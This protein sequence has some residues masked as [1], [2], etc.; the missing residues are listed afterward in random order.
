VV[1][2]QDNSSGVKQITELALSAGNSVSVNAQMGC[3]LQTEDQM[4]AIQAQSVGL[5]QSSDG[6]P[7]K[8][9]TALGHRALA[10][11]DFAVVATFVTF[12]ILA[13]ICL[14][15]FCPWSEEISAALA[16]L[17]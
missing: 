5:P 16:T 12:G 4:Q 3:F 11:R 15:L 9:L 8:V 2:A 10:N 1:E 13:W 6:K 17:S 14:V 7:S